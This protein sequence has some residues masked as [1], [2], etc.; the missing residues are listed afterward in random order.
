[1]FA[2]QHS[3]IVSFCHLGERGG[4]STLSWVVHRVDPDRV[5]DR[6]RFL[7][8]AD[9]RVEDVASG[10]LDVF[11]RYAEA[12]EPAGGFACQEAGAGDVVGVH[13]NG[14]PADHVARE[15]NR[16]ALGDEQAG[17]AGVDYGG[18]MADAR[19]HKDARVADVNSLEK[20]GK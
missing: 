8:Y 15:C 18:V 1:V 4:N 7:E 13:M 2:D 3:A 6:H 14:V 17:S 16:V 12:G 20:R 5:A 10:A 19:A 9:A 11:S